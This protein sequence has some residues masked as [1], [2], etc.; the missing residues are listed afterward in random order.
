MLLLE[1]L[2]VTG[3]LSLDHT[4][5]AVY[6]QSG[7]FPENTSL[8]KVFEGFLAELW[9]SPLVNREIYSIDFQDGIVNLK[10]C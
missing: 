3:P 2:F 6:C 8:D 10:L 7:E 9:S 5:V 4:R 1:L